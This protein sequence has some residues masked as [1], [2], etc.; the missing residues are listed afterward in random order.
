MAAVRWPIVSGGGVAACVGGRR[1]AGWGGR[2]GS[3][4]ADGVDVPGDG[5]HAVVA[6][7]RSRRSTYARPLWTA[8]TGD[9]LPGGW[10]WRLLGAAARAACEWSE[11]P[12]RRGRVAVGPRT[13][14]SWPPGRVGGLADGWLGGCGSRV[15]WLG[16]RRRWRVTGV[17]WEHRVSGGAPPLAER[18]TMVR[19][20]CGVASPWRDGP[21]ACAAVAVSRVTEMR[22]AAGGGAAH[23]RRRPRLWCRMVTARVGGGL[24]T[25]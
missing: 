20:G 15:H 9:S 1:V 6:G 24:P 25:A 3:P 10:T 14:C 4:L 22:T 23:G 21:H 19:R 8:E 5:R 11:R 13:G 18:V 12:G 7:G 16:L 17:A 2:Q